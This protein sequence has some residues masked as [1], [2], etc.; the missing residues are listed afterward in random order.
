MER[1][2]RI[3][4]RVLKLVD[5]ANQMHSSDIMEKTGLDI[6]DIVNACLELM[7]EGK[8]EFAPTS[9]LSTSIFKDRVKKKDSNNRSE[10]KM[11]N[12]DHDANLVFFDTL[13]F[14][15]GAISDAIHGKL[16]KG[17]GEAVIELVKRLFE[18]HGKKFNM[19]LPEP[20]KLR[21]IQ[22]KPKEKNK[23]YYVR[24]FG[25]EEVCQ[26]W[27]SEIGCGFNFLGQPYWL[28]SCVGFEFSDRPIPECE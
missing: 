5:E 27:D 19:Q 7:K 24:K 13:E 11:K 1:M 3:K 28:D 25:T 16:E 21:Y 12:K 4:K 9:G 8:V 17:G 15:C 2:E 23:R 6:E 26:I 18:R 22:E 14:C 10:D 20:P